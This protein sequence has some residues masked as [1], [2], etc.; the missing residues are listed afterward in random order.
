[1]ASK[2]FRRGIRLLGKE[3]EDGKKGKKEGVSG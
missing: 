2:E 3:R 1:M